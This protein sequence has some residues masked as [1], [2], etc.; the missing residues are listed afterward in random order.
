MQL[1]LMHETI[2]EAL[3]EVVKACGGIK[4]IGAL[5]WPELPPDQA[6]NKLRD[7]LNTD[8]REKLSPAQVMFVLKTGREQ[9]VHAAMNFIARECGYADPQPI[10]PESEVARLQREYIEA[11][12]LLMRT[13]SRIETL[14]MR[15][16]G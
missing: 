7:C 15:Q 16:A 3:Q 13:A 12:K 9:G 2:D 1:G 14:Q 6:G 8:R 4:A 10:E 11:T 5:L